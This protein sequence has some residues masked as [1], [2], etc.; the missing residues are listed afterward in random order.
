MPVARMR[1]RP[2]L[3]LQI[4][5]NKIPGLCWINKDRRIFQIPWKHAARHGWNLE[6]DAC[7]FRNWAVHTGRFKQGMDKP[8]P[9]TW[10]ANFRCAMNSL[11]DIEEVKDKSVNKGSSAIRVYRMLVLSTQKEKRARLCKEIKSKNKRTKSKIKEEATESAAITLPTDHTTYTATEQ[12]TSQEMVAD[13]TVSIEEFVSSESHAAV[14][15]LSEWNRNGMG[16]ECETIARS[17]DLY[18][19]QISPLPSPTADRFLS[20]EECTVELV[21]ENS[22]WEHNTIEGRGYYSNGMGTIPLNIAGCDVRTSEQET[23]HPFLDDTIDLLGYDFRPQLEMKS[24]M[25]LL[26]IF[27]YPNWQTGTLIGCI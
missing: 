18:Q 14:H 13:S 4:D 24:G 23:M 17:C 25:D 21:P 7:L 11:P 9:K 8:E 1:M 20:G 10:K 19:F 26:N 6:T 22:T 12:Y 16:G 15:Q 3:E 5:S 2:W 27:D